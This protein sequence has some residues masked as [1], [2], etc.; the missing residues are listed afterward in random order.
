[1]LPMPKALK[2]KICNSCSEVNLTKASF[3]NGGHY[4][5][6]ITNLSHPRYGLAWAQLTT[7]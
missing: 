4:F 7:F 3:G 5:A 1:M 6:T 2:P